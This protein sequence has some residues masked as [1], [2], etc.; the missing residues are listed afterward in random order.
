MSPTK[1]KDSIALSS[2][3]GIIED[4]LGKSK[5]EDGTILGSDMYDGT[6]VKAKFI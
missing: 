3:D 1:T 4:C 2:L 6:W 5:C